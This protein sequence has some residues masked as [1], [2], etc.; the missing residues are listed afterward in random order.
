MALTPFFYVDKTQL[1]AAKPQRFHSPSNTSA[2]RAK[3][4]VT[5]IAGTVCVCLK[6]CRFVS[7]CLSSSCDNV[8]TV[9]LFSDFSE[10]NETF[11]S[12][13]DELQSEADRE[14]SKISTFKK[15]PLT[16]R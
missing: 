14:V 13:V 7:L 8:T 11:L 16:G 2:Q 9:K 10:R 4:D 5:L 3:Q 15:K 6:L 1:R 12:R